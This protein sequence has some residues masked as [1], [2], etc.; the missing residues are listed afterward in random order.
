MCSPRDGHRTRRAT[1]D[2]FS[3]WGG[4]EETYSQLDEVLSTAFNTTNIKRHLDKLRLTK[5]ASVTFSLFWVCTT[6]P[7]PCSGHW[8]PVKGCPPGRLHCQR[9]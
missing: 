7:S 3:T 5:A 6:Y 2:R 8:L 1:I 9:A 4:S